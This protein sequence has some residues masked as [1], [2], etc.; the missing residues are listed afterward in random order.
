MNNAKLHLLLPFICFFKKQCDILLWHSLV[1]YLGKT[2]SRFD[3]YNF[4]QFHILVCFSFTLPK[5]LITPWLPSVK[6]RGRVSLNA[7]TIIVQVL[8][9]NIGLDAI[10]NKFK[11]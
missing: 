1:S 10:Q 5:V 6:P 11:N 4:T 8:G 3:L 7:N 2:V 9:S